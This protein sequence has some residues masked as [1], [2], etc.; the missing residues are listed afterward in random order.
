MTLSSDGSS[1]MEVRRAKVHGRKFV[2][3][4]W[5]DESPWMEIRWAKVRGR[6]LDEQKSVDGSPINKRKSTTHYWRPW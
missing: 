1:W 4:S 5:M 3:G 2:D 6:K